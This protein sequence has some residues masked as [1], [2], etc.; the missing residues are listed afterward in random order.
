[1][2]HPRRPAV[3]WLSQAA[4][5]TPSASP[6]RSSVIGILGG[7]GYTEA[8]CHPAVSCLPSLWHSLLFPLIRETKPRLTFA[9]RGHLSRIYSF[10]SIMFIFNIVLFMTKY[11]TFCS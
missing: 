8:E 7:S 6:A 10:I 4:S 9:G 1:M 2:T 11:T 3:R 5:H